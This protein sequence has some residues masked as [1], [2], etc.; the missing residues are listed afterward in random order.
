MGV[1]EMIVFI[2]LISTIGKVVSERRPKL[3]PQDDGPRLGPGEA[4]SIVQALDELNSRVGRLEEERDFYKE[5][6]ESPE[7]KRRL[8][9]PDTQG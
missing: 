9:D 6:L 4:D 8:K 5:L 3:P 1:F 7:A 2:V